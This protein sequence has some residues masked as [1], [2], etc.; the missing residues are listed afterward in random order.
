[1]GVEGM[2]TRNNLAERCLRRSVIWSKMCFGTD[3]EAGSRFVS[4]ILSVVTTLRM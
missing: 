1:M 3:S 2:P 4:R